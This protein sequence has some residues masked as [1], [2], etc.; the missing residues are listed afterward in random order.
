[1]L[2]ASRTLMPL[3][4]GAPAAI[5]ANLDKITNRQRARLVAVG[6]LTDCQ[7]DAINQSRKATGHP[8]IEATIVF[9]GQHIYNSRV[10]RDGYT[11]DDVIDQI[12]SA[13][14]AV[15]VVISTPR[16]TVIENPNP[17]AD[18][19]GNAVRDRAILECSARYP[20]PELFSVVP[21]GDVMRPKK[22]PLD[23]RP[24]PQRLARVTVAS[25]APVAAIPSM[26]PPRLK[27]Q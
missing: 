10:L 23:E 16:M 27:S 8:P 1:M 19:Y 21:K 13:L 22:R 7:L 26:T 18:H 3:L 9:L 4:D 24:E 20:K 6:R 11:I 17:R 5:R 12:T 2:Y 15:A 14:D 25:G